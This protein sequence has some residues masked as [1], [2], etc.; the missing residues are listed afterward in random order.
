MREPLESAFLTLLMLGVEFVY[1]EAK[2]RSSQDPDLVRKNKIKVSPQL[3]RRLLLGHL[4]KLVFSVRKLAQDF[5]SV[6]SPLKN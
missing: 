6:T 1:G 2:Q 4:F 3:Q 5:Y